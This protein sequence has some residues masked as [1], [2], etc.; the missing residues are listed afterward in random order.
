MSMALF[1]RAVTPAEAEVMSKDASMVDEIVEREGEDVLATDIQDA[2]DVLMKLLRGAGFKGAR[3]L[4]ECLSNGG[5][6]LS[7][8]Q[9]KIHATLL[10][11][12]TPGYVRRL[13]DEL[14]SPGLYH[15]EAWKDD[16]DGLVAEFVKLQD[17]YRQAA[18]RGLAIVFYSA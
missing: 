9:V 5:E 14:D 18:A 7:A 13:F 8:E 15:F 4:G 17:F 12:Y 3:N 11:A 16:P 2:W 6:L 10:A 1:L